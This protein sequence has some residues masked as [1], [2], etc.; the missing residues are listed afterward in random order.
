MEAKKVATLLLASAFMF[1]LAACSMKVDKTADGKDKDVDIKSPFGNLSVHKGSDV[2][3]TGIELYANA[4]RKQ[5]DKESDDAANVNLSVPG[6]GMK[7]VAV[8][9]TTDDSPEKVLRFYRGSFKK[10]FATVVECRGNFGDVHVNNEEAKDLDKPVTC[11]SGGHGGSDTVE[12]KAG[13]RGNQH[14]VAIKPDGKGSEFKLVYLKMQTKSDKDP[15]K[16][17]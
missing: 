1:G 11:E 5:G 9:Y 2:K 16:A 13:T 10:S 8:T 12:L 4:Q 15:D 6:F 17:I 14:V 3:D 7:V